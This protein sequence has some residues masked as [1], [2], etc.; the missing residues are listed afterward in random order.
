MR[1]TMQLKNIIEKGP[2]GIAKFTFTQSKLK[3]ITLHF[4]AELNS[5]NL[6]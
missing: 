5:R 1:W 4:D 3:N 6:L 2:Y